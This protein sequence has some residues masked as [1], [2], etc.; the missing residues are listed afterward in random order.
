LIAEPVLVPAVRA[1]PGDGVAGHAP[2][3]LIH[4]CLADIEATSTVPAEAK[5]L[6]AAVALKA[7]L[8]AAP[9]PVGNGWCGLFHGCCLTTLLV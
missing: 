8:S 3:V 2:D 9:A 5:L 4:A 1:L 6:G 7:F